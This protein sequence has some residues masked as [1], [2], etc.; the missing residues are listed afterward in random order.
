MAEAWY[1]LN[2]KMRRENEAREE[3]RELGFECFLPLEIRRRKD[4]SK[5]HRPEVNYSVAMIPGYIFP[6]FDISKPCGWQNLGRLHTVKGWLKSTH[7][8][9]P[10]PMRDQT[11]IDR[12]KEEQIAVAAALNNDQ[13]IKL[14]P[15]PA[16]TRII[17]QEGP[18]ASFGGLVNMTVGDRVKVMLD[19]AG[20]SALEIARHSVAVA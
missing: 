13:A 10:R 15:I 12:L 3:I 1:V 8:E 17:I 16:G 20:F 18:F 2:T 11:F 9:S 7:L 4:R 6:K 19:A 14:E 5:K